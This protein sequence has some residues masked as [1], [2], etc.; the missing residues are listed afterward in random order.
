MMHSGCKKWLAVGLWQW[1]LFGSFA[2]SAQCPPQLRLPYNSSWLPYVEVKKGKVAGSD[3]ELLRQVSKDVGS[4]L[5]LLYMPESRALNDLAA[6]KV[7]L[8][9]G[10]SYTDKRAKIAWFSTSYREEVTVVIVHPLLLQRYPELNTKTAF[11]YL[12][13]RKLAGTVNPIGFY[14]VE[15][16]QL[17]QQ[18]SVQNRLVAIFDAEQRLALVLNQRADFTL[19]DQVSIKVRFALHPIYQQL[20]VLPFELYRD[21]IHLMLSKKT[22][23]AACLALINQSLAKYRRG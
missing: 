1:G 6:G 14:G 21:D 13:S 18:P 12:A 9:F 23:T 3:I 7:D 11:L 2:L 4:E 15:F 22:I 19:A 8:L 16:E 17:K 20:S 10:A 5:Q